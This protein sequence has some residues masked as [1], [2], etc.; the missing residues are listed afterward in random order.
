MQVYLARLLLRSYRRFT[1]KKGISIWSFQKQTLS[2][3]FRQAKLA[4]YEGVELSLDASGEICMDST[5]KEIEQIKSQADAAGVSLYSI[6][7]NLHW[8]YSLTSNDPTI[9]EQA[10]AVIR[11]QLDI[12]SWLGCDTVL[13]VPGAVGVDFIPNCEIIDYDIAY[14]R[15]MN[16]MKELAPYAEERG[17]SIALENVGNKLLLSPLE[18]RDFIDN[19]GSD[20]VGAYFDVGNVLR[21]GYPEQWIRILNRRI[22]KIHIKDFKRASNSFVSLMAGDVDFPAVIKALR[23]IG[24]TDWLTA[25]MMPLYQHYPEMILHTTS[26]AMDAIMGHKTV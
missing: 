20:Y 11:K 1:M 4:G 24:Y 5:Q 8:E 12:A 6:A 26:M 17:V 25:E 7:T 3:T 18:F 23:D 14:D 10:K 22:K 15:A 9:R 2:E 21:T 13:V 19:V 16:A